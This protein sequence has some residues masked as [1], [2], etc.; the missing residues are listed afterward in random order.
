MT[1]MRDVSPAPHVPAEPDRTTDRAHVRRELAVLLGEALVADYL[2][3]IRGDADASVESRWGPHHPD[4][5]PSD[6]SRGALI[7]GQF[8]GRTRG[9]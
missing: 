4:P 8:G 7:R 5:G 3:Q 2:Q 1:T 6:G 9:R